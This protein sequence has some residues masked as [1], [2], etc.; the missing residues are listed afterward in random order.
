MT[1]CSFRHHLIDKDVHDRY[2]P[3]V[4]VGPSSLSF[5]KLEDS[6]AIYGFHDDF[7]KGDWYESIRDPKTQEGNIFGVRSYAAHRERRKLLLGPAL[8][9][10]KIAAYKPVII[11]HVEELIRS[12]SEAQNTTSS[13]FTNVA[14]VLHRFTL[15]TLFEVNLH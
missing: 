7:E 2:G 8:S 6:E 10:G 15:E 11:K 1:F 14:Q 5:S 13:E 9:S 3:V 4:R 12:I